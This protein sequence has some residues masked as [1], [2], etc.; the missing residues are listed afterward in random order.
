MTTEWAVDAAAEQFTLDAQ[1]HGELT[2][3]VTNP[4]AVTDIAVFDVVPGAGAQVSWF[5]VDEPQRRI[6]GHNGFASFL[7]KA[8]VPVGTPAGR[9]EIYG[10]ASSADTAPEESARLSGRVTLDIAAQE[11]KKF[12][13]LPVAVGAVLLL[14]V[15]GVVGYLVLKP[16]GKKTPPPVAA[17]VTDEAETLA[18]QT[19]TTV[20]SNTGAQVTTQDNCC[21][22]TWS[23][24]K[25]LW[26]QGRAPGD[27]VTMTFTVPVDGTYTF[28]AVRTTSFDYANT[29]FLIDNA[30][31]G[32]VFFGYSAQPAI[33]GWVNEGS[34][35]LT[36]GQHRLTL[37]II[38]KVQATTSFYAGVDEVRFT[39][40]LP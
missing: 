17:V 3:T 13:W 12:P 36:A 34:V 35:R 26:F 27:S 8:A 32:G 39:Q 25:Q 16:S 9:Y 38:G 2:F 15:L 1:Q 11:K 5:T 28:A 10:R 21:S 23:G 18:G 6:P 20:A 22:I 7:V 14:I 31:V 29:R 37:F 4:G 30:P 33:T 40:V 19:D 24:G